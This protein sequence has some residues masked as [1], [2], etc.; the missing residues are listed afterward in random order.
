[1]HKRGND[2]TAAVEIWEILIESGEYTF[3]ALEELAKYHE[4]QKKDIQSSFEYTSRA[5]KALDLLNQLESY[6]PSY[7]EFHR[8]FSHRFERL[9]SKL[10]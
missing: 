6:N 1:M 7:E 5:L 4:H 8:K 3:S 9:K 10:S 2:W